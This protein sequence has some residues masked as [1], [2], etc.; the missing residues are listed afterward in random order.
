M[1]QDDFAHCSLRELA[2]L[3]RRRETSP[4]ELAELVLRRL[5]RIGKWLNAVV[6]LTAERAL[7]EA[8]RAEAELVAGIDRG[9]LHG[10]PYGAKDLLAAAGYPTTWGAVSLRQQH[11]PE[12]ATAI[13]RLREAGAVLVAKLATVE[14][15]GGMGYEQPHASFTGPGINPW[16]VDAWSGGSSTGPAAAVAAD[17]VPFALGTETWGS[18]IVPASYC[19]VTG[20]RP[21]S[22]RVSRF[23]AMTLSWTLDKIGPLARSAEDCALVLAAVAGPDPRDPATIPHPWSEALVSGQKQ[24]FRIGVLETGLE[25]AQPEVVANFRAALVLLSEFATLEP[26]VLPDRPY[27]EVI[28]IVLSAEAA[29]AFEELVASGA[30]RTLTAPEDRVGGIAGLTIPAVD[31]LRAQ[32]IRRQLREELTSLLAP[33][34]AIVAPSTLVVASPLTSRFDDYAGPARRTPLSAASNLA[35]FPAI[36]VPNGFG[37]RGLPTGLQFVGRAGDESTLLALA[38]S[39]QARTDWHCRRPPLAFA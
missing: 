18:I 5:E 38:R 30:T 27:G 10:I 8:R 20:L 17:F 39:Y 9:P 19:G 32:R 23:G 26:I 33:Y 22:G 11:F 35:G 29:S 6:T 37:E 13:A 36:S 4:V 12:D 1:T 15:A 16:N 31:Y 7:D 14:L 2:V 25:F 21:T 28:R 24:I 3:L 34:D